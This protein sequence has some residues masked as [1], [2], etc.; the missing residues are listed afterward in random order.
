M[1]I[2]YNITFYNMILGCKPFFRILILVLIW[3]ND[4]VVCTLKWKGMNYFVLNC[5]FTSNHFTVAQVWHNT[6]ETAYY[7]SFITTILA[8]E[9]SVIFHNLSFKVYCHSVFLIVVV[10]LL[11]ASIISDSDC[12]L[13]LDLKL[14]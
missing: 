12:F 10:L 14:P 2:Q 1:V 9:A 5:A 3:I 13:S 11:Y 7:L 8:I 4:S 6:R